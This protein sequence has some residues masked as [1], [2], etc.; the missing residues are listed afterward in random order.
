MTKYFWINKLIIKLIF[1]DKLAC[2][3]KLGIDN[4]IKIT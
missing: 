4:G 2:D 3:R 1:L